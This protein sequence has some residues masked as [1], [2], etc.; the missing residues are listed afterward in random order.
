M[1]KGIR[2]SVCFTTLDMIYN[3][4]F[5]AVIS[6]KVLALM[7]AIIRYENTIDPTAGSS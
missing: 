3:S 4:I 6:K 5:N 2:D 7:P 1:K